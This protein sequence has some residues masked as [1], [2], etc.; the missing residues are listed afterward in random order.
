MNHA[1]F[2]EKIRTQLTQSPLTIP[3]I[4]IDDSRRRNAGRCM[5]QLICNR[6]SQQG[7]SPQHSHGT[8]FEWQGG[9]IALRNSRVADGFWS[10]LFHRLKRKFTRLHQK[11]QWLTCLPIG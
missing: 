10:N 9:I 6:L 2:A 4:E 11:G 8:L 1:E 3:T 5:S 7:D